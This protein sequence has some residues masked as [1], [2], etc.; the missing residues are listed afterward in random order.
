MHNGKACLKPLSQAI[1]D[2]K[3]TGNAHLESGR[4]QEAAEQYTIA[5]LRLKDG[6][7]VHF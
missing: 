4:P 6:F 5:L 1:L 3:D 7:G 2:L